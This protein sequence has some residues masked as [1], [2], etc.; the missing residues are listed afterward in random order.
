[1]ITAAFCESGFDAHVAEL[2]KTLHG[3]LEAT[4]DAVEQQF[5]TLATICRPHGGI[6]LWIGFPPEIDVTKLVAPAASA[7]VS[8]NPGPEWAAEPES[9]RNWLRLC[10]AMPDKQTI[11]DGVAKLAEVC[12]DV[13]GVPKF[14]ANTRRGAAQ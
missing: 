10:F 2:K 11:Y 8:F 3:K 6:F 5:G 7:G 1:M 4:I 13:Y 14:S 12:H 9:A